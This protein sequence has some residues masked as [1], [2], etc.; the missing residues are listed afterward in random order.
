MSSLAKAR[1]SRKPSEVRESICLRLACL[2]LG[3]WEVAIDT[4][5]GSE[6]CCT[7]SSHTDGL[8][9]C[10]TSSAKAAVA[11]REAVLGGGGE[12]GGEGAMQ[13]EGCRNPVNGSPRFA[14][15]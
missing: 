1:L 9:R 7:P 14:C 15:H 6:E 13:S 12:G 8:D 2:M 10:P 3:G 11:S 5:G 4:P